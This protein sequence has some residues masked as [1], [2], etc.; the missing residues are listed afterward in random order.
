MK[1]KI[2]VEQSISGTVL[3]VT[4]LPRL[5]MC[6]EIFVVVVSSKRDRKKQC[7]QNDSRKQSKIVS[8]NTFSLFF[9]IHNVYSIAQTAT[10]DR[11]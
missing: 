1:R 7:K 2:R 3:S 5:T 10:D 4:F 8:I 6:E 11:K 9:V